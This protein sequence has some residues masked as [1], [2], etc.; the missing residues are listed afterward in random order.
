MS[1]VENK[2]PTL[3]SRI[4]SLIYDSN[5]DVSYNDAN[6]LDV[7]NS[8]LDPPQCRQ[9]LLLYYYHNS[10]LLKVHLCGYELLLNKTSNKL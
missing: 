5:L 1:F 7:K 10:N 9:I 6:T 3:R 2:Q 8:L 4:L